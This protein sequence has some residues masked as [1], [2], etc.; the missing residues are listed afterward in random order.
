MTRRKSSMDRETL[1]R[2]MGERKL[3]VSEIFS[4]S[5]SL[6]SNRFG[7][8]LLLSV[9]VF[10]PANVILQYFTMKITMVDLTGV[11][12]LTA[13]LTPYLQQYIH[14]IVANLTAEFIALIAILVTAVQVKN[15]LFD[16]KNHSFGTLFYR[17]IRM[18]PRAALTQV[19]VLLQMV[20]AVIC[21][22]MLLAMPLIGLIAIALLLLIAVRFVMY[23]NFCGAAAALRGRMGFDN[24]R[25][26]RFLLHGKSMHYIGLFAAVTV[27][28]NG[29]IILVS[30]LSS[31]LF[32]AFTN[33]YVNM[34]ISVGLS[35]LLSILNIFGYICGTL[36][37]FNAEE[38][39]R[40]ELKTL[41]VTLQN[42]QERS[43][44]EESLEAMDEGLED[45]DSSDDPEDT[46][47]PKES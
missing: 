22:S 1:I 10:L 15:Q 31:N 27:L 30:L 16:E 23:E 9:L 34:A 26:V 19:L 36:A 28:S 20:V 2:T 6:L 44:V 47:G 45:E 40:N 4:S 43:M 12:L 35:T 37:L 33:E 8:Y 38:T 42:P 7:S 39:K 11:D 41:S 18:W 5:Y 32:M 13:D 24:L 46:D 17:G 29:I 25:Y 3:R 14:L 21:C